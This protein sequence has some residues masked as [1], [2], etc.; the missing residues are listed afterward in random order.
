VEGL[1]VL[2][3]EFVQPERGLHVLEFLGRGLHHAEPDEPR[4]APAHGGRG[5]RRHRLGALSPAV[6]VVRAV[7]DH[8]VIGSPGQQA[9]NPEGPQPGR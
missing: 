4:F 9:V 5:L 2:D 8:A 3:G 6:A 1:G 7:D